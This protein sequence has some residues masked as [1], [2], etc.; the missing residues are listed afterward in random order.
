MKNTLSLSLLSVALLSGCTSLTYHEQQEITRL[1][2]QGINIDRPQGQWEKPAS[3]LVAGL[4]NILPGIG[5][6]YLASGRAGDSSHWIYGFGNLLLWPTSIIWAVPEAA[7]DADNINKRD[8]LNYYRYG[9]GS[10]YQ[11]V[12]TYSQPRG[13]YYQQPQNVYY[14]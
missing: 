12:P 3:P 14:R 5:N 7:L 4:L 10:V 6:F 11:N 9:N 13:Q 8:M 1:Q 2:Y